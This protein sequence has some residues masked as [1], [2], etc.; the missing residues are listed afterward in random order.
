[1]SMEHTKETKKPLLDEERMEY[2]GGDD[3]IKCKDIVG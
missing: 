2:D 3:D 1:M